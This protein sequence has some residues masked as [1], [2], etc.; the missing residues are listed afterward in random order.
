[1]KDKF[2][3]K[4]MRVARLIG[5]DQNPCHSRHIGAIIVEP[6]ANRII[7]TGYNGPPSGTPHPESLEFLREYFWPQLT[8]DE[9]SSLKLSLLSTKELQ[10]G[11]SDSSLCELFILKYQGKSICPRRIVGAKSGQRSELCSCGHAERHAITNAAQNC[12]G[13]YMF[14]WCGVP[15]LQCADAIIQ[16]GIVRVYCLDVP[17]YHERSRWLFSTAGVKIIQHAPEW[18]NIQ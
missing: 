10:T 16:A 4:W 8:D 14:C 11:V 5:E 2:V 13:C 15:C 7:G 1:M 3:K 17:D 12:Y 18:F 9:K 6:M